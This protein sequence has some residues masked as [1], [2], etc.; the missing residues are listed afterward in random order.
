[1]KLRSNEA[2]WTRHT[3][4]GDKPYNH[5]MEPEGR[6]YGQGRIKRSQCLFFLW[7]NVNIQF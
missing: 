4:K 6:D 1:M 3:S 5:P 7:L 2:E